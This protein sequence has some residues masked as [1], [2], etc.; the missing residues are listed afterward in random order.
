MTKKSYEQEL[1]ELLSDKHTRMNN[2]YKVV[3][4]YGEVTQFVMNESQEKLFNERHTLNIILKA[5]QLGF[6]TLI[7]LDALDSC[8]FNENFSAGLIADTLDNAHRLLERVKFSYDQL[9]PDIRQ[10]IQIVKKNASE[11][12]F[13]NGSKII[14]GMSLR[15]ATVNFLHISEYGAICAKDPDRANQIKSGSLNT[16]APGQFVYIESTAEGKGGDFHRKTEEAMKIMYEGRKPLAMEYKFHFFPWYEDK[17]YTL[18]QRVSISPEM[19]KYLDELEV[20][21]DVK[22]SDGQRAWYA[23]KTVEQGDAIFKEFPSTPEEAFQAAR[24]GSYF[25]KDMAMLR[26]RGLIKE[27]NFDPRFPVNTFWDL[28]VGESDYMT[29]WMHQSINGMDWFVGYF[30]G[31]G[32]GLSY[33]FNELEIWRNT[34]RTLWGEHFGPHDMD[35]PRL[36]V[37]ADSAADIAA[38]LGWDFNIVPKTPDKKSTIQAARMALPTCVFDKVE[39]AAGIDH[40]EN[41]SRQFDDKNGVWRAKPAHNEHSHAADAFFTFVDGYASQKQTTRV[42]VEEYNVEN[43]IG[44]IV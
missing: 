30:E 42:K 37:T 41:Y 24:D 35:H 27:L 36:G 17:K 25:A 32:E 44:A 16:I 40:L 39:C 8:L 33:Y 22:L 3:D 1:Y 5:R 18:D 23:L 2:L 12:H 11:I 15:S 43:A 28:G 7:L 31:E 13:S 26:Q 20:K 38:D 6:S 21:Q 14:V 29:I 4:P 19:R 9:H 34:R 10:A